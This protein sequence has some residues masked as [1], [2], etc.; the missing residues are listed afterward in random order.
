MSR[1]SHGSTAALV[2]LLGMIAS[3]QLSAQTSCYDYHPLA[4]ERSSTLYGGMAQDVAIEG[5]LAVLACSFMSIDV[6]DI[7]NPDNIAPVRSIYRQSPSTTILP[8]YNCISFS[9]GL[10]Y[11]P[12]ENVLQPGSF[13]VAVYDPDLYPDPLV[14]ELAIPTIANGI[15]VS[16]HIGFVADEQGLKILDLSSPDPENWYLRAALP[17]QCPAQDL[18]LVDQYVYIADGAGGVAI[19]SCDNL[20]TP[21]IVGS[22]SWG[23][24]SEYRSLCVFNNTLCLA[25]KGFLEL[26]DITT[27]TIPVFYSNRVPLQ[28][29]LVGLSADA[30]TVYAAIQWSGIA[31]VDCA[32]PAEPILRGVESA[33]ANNVATYLGNVYPAENTLIF[34]CLLGSAITNRDYV[35]GYSH[36]RAHAHDIAISGNYAYVANDEG[37]PNKSLSNCGVDPDQEDYCLEIIDISNPASPFSVSHKDILLDGAA[38]PVSCIRIFGDRAYAG[39][40]Y[41]GVAIFD[42][43]NKTAPIQVGAWGACLDSWVHTIDIDVIGTQMCTTDIEGWLRIWDIADPGSPVLLSSSNSKYG[44]RIES[45]LMYVASGHY[46]LRI[47]D[48][49]NPSTPALVGAWSDPFSDARRLEVRNGIVYLIDN[50]AHNRF[51]IIDARNPA[52]PLLMDAVTLS[53]YAEAFAVT[54]NTAYV[55]IF[56]GGMTVLDVSDPSDIEIIGTVTSNNTIMD[57]SVKGD[58]IYLAE[59][60]NRMSVASRQCGDYDA[61]T[62]RYEDRSTETNLDYDGTPYS[63]VTMDYNNDGRKDMFISIKDAAGVLYRERDYMSEHAVPIFDNRNQYDFAGGSEPQIGLRGLAAADYDNDGSIDFF[64][65]ALTGARLYHNTGAA[66]TDVASTTGIAVKA[67]DSWGGCWGDYDRDGKV[68]LFITRG[69]QTGQDPTPDGIAPAQGYLMSNQ[70]SSFLDISTFCGI[71]T[72]NPTASVAAAWVDVDGDN[73]LDLYLGELRSYNGVNTSRFYIQDDNGHFTDEHTSRIGLLT[74]GIS[75]VTWADYDNDGDQDLTL[76]SQIHNPL[77]YINDGTG[78]FGGSTIMT[79]DVNNSHNIGV[80]AYD[81]NLDGRLDALV[82]P[83][84]ASDHPWLLGNCLVNSGMIFADQSQTARLDVSTGR[85]DGAVAADFNEDGDQDVYLGRARTTENRKYFY[86]AVQENETDAPAYDWVGIRLQAGPGNNKAA[87]G[88]KVKL[89]IG[90]SY[91]HMRQVDGGSGRGGQSDNLLMFGLGDMAGAVQAVVKWPGGFSQT[92][93]LTRNQITTIIDDTNP[94]VVGSSVTSTYT[95]KPGQKADWLFEWETQYNCAESLDKVMISD[96]SNPPQCETFGSIVLQ[97]GSPGVVHSVRRKPGGGYVHSLK[98]TDVNCIPPCTYNYQ[99]QSATDSQHQS[100]SAQ[101]QIKI[102][103]CIN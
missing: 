17:L 25:D 56:E 11:A 28:G 70:G 63:S 16:N 13:F 79:L 99:V 98:W 75:S 66:F 14:G 77:V 53:N 43:S 100:T 59:A 47:F 97:P 68:D 91:Q 46:G 18:V 52:S 84:N 76:G 33:A 82:L 94:T 30:S 60:W 103:I 38:V 69:I 42:I 89:V 51:S 19:V 35:L 23:T 27:R 15:I 54:A 9:S 39:L 71:N 41:S 90:T 67:T 24:G 83:E 4:T 7:S 26:A 86:R 88:T 29:C 8:K 87:V 20:D 72:G 37:K 50:I 45:G 34:R 22:L 3:G 31:R 85:V 73:D 65:A 93:G 95:P 48:I 62:V 21:A 74:A 32:S 61:T 5:S 10:V 40:G 49:S 36:T 44:V 58:Y 96:G 1:S 101:K 6:I 57:V 102:K 12:Y 64:A 81:H 2:V 78:H 80:M 55:A 92:V